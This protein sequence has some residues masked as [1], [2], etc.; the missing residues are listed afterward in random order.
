MNNRKVDHSALRTNQAFIIT[1]VALAFIAD[2]RWLVAFV[3]AVLLIG[4]VFPRIA[5][6][7]AAVWVYPETVEDRPARCARR[8][9]GATPVCPGGW[10][11][12]PAG[13]DVSLSSSVSR[14]WAGLCPGS[15]LLWPR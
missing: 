11:D 12:F 1:L 15:S 9:S 8:Q 10:W 14:R 4:T 5:L 2:A 3:S 6:F 13:G 7:K